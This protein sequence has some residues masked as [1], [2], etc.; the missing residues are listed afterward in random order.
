[1]GKLGLTESYEEMVEK[2]GKENADF[3][4]A[5]VGDWEKNYSAYL[6][7][8]MGVCDE[9][10]LVQAGREDA[11]KLGWSFNVRKGD[12]TLLRRLF[13]GPWNED[14]IV[15]PP[16]KKIVARNDAYVPRPPV[17]SRPRRPATLR[18]A[19]VLRPPAAHSPDGVSVSGSR[20]RSNGVVW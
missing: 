2:Y 13:E 11:K 10:T 8:T 9:E 18:G 16:G 3:L 1:M 19:S 17:G 4:M 14:F 6:Y 5:T 20:L 12:I 7:L 15:V